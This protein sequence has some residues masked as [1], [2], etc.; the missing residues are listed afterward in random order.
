M[1]VK[2]IKWIIWKY[3]QQRDDEHWTHSIRI[4][5]VSWIILEGL[6][7]ILATIVIYLNYNDALKVSGT[8]IF[9]KTEWCSMLMAGGFS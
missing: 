2:R 1:H 3:V 8:E 5:R 4:H 7:T 9:E 6:V